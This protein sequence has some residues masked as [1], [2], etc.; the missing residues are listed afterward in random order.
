MRKHISFV[1]QRDA[2]QCGVA[3]LCMVARRFGMSCSVERVE[4]VCHATAEGVSLKGIG[5]GASA[6]G[7]R[8]LAARVSPEGLRS[9]P[10]PAILHWNQNHFVVLYHIDRGG[11]R[12]RVADPGKGLLRYTAEEFLPHW[13]SG[14][15]G[16][17]ETGIAMF[18][19][20]DGKSE[21]IVAENKRTQGRC[22]SFAF[23][24]AHIGRYR[25]YFLHILLGLL[26]GCVLQ[27]LIP[28]LTQSI[29]DTGIR[30]KDIGFIWLVLSGELMIITGRTATDFIRRHLL[31][32]ISMRINLSLVSDFLI[33][34]LNLPMSFFDTRL[35]GDLLQRMGDHSRVQSFLTGQTLGILF[36]IL[37]FI[38]FGGVLLIYDALIFGVFIAG[39]VCY[40]LWTV[41]F[42][43]RRRVLD[44]ELFEQQAINQNRTYQ[45]LTSVQEIKLQDCE[46]R[47]RREWEDTQADLFVIQ[48]KSLRL[49]QR[50]EA[51]SVFINEIRNILITVLA[52]GA[53][54]DGGMTLGGMLAVQYITGQLGAPVSQMMGFIYALQ[55]VGISLER[56]NDIYGRRDEDS[57][58]DLY[59][60]DFAGAGGMELRNVCFRY[61]PHSP[62]DTLDDISFS[63]PAG[64]VTAIVGS[65]GSGKS[66]L[67]KLLLGYYPV[68]SGSITVAGH[69]INTYSMRSW[70][71]RCG[72]VMQEGVIFSESIARN[73][74]AGDGDI[75]RERLERAAR[76]ACIHDYVMSL[77]LR[78]ETKIGKDGTGLSRGQQQRILIARAVYR[79]PDFIFLDE[80][81]NALDAANERA[82]VENLNGFYRGRTVVIVAHR[83]STVRNADFIIV[84]DGG[85]VAETGTHTTLT[86][87]KGLYYSLVRNQ[88]ELGS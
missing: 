57:G 74:A 85:R 7:L 61:D 24:V 70:R 87:R 32:H 47:R 13:L 34:L 8:S 22:R 80:A 42:L 19:E 71:R 75:D 66:T 45:F 14:R 2:M 37:S 54:I 17:T 60:A 50:Q 33:K 64:K 23:L 11:R 16:E 1:R 48:M 40:G 10:L 27:L 36:S 51:G 31:L 82:I 63:I 79:E 52:A 39:S 3:C 76:T 77:P 6:L 21:E 58:E 43:R 67:L 68:R 88:L 62:E 15:T 41:S 78:Y 65:S 72:V 4:E 53:V 73:I 12:Y 81:T 84:L 83:L 69:D 30:N 18:F 26:A 44:Y 20:P 29:V 25:R 46:G 38:V 86:E 49:Q 9:M 59:P 28:F 5:D 35:S 56:I 55:D